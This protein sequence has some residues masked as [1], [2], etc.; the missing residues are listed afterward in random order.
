MLSRGTVVTV[1]GTESR[2]RPAAVVGRKDSQSSRRL[3]HGTHHRNGH[4]GLPRSRYSGVAETKV[5]GALGRR[6]AKGCSPPRPSC[7]PTLRAAQP[8][9]DDVSRKGCHAVS[10]RPTHAAARRPRK[11]G[12]SPLFMRRYPSH[13]VEV[14]AGLISATP[15]ST[16]TLPVCRERFPPKALQRTLRD[17]GHSRGGNKKRSALRHRRAGPNRFGKRADYTAAGRR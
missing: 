14:I 12:T 1:I 11:C 8:L 10:C 6:S 5:I 13:R 9:R 15:C 16:T 17:A 4:W 7:R 3:I 2:A